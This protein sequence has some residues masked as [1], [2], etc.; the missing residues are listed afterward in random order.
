[1]VAAALLL[2]TTSR[3]ADHP[4]NPSFSSS[5]VSLILFHTFTPPSGV[6][7]QGG[8]GETFNFSVFNVPASSGTTASMTLFDTVGGGATSSI[9]LN[10]GT[11]T[12]LPASS[13]APMSLV[14]DTSLPGNHSVSYTLKFTSNPTPSQPD[15]AIGASATVYR[16]GDYDL[17]HDVDNAD[18]AL[19]RSAIGSTA[20]AADGNENGVVDAADFVVWRNNFTGPGPLG[21]AADVTSG[22]LSP[23][24]GVPEPSAFLMAMLAAGISCL[25]RPRRRV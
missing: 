15:L 12:D 8:P 2:A 14:L 17:D 16:R 10:A 13:S 20:P 7:R 23:T 24:G 21:A 22:E 3:A 6:F 25:R 5:S 1:M 9:A 19:W 11:I 4:A 18:Y